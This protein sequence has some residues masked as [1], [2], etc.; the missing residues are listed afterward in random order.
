VGPGDKPDTI[1]RMKQ[2][3]WELIVDESGQPDARLIF[4]KID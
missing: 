4:R 2:K 3:G 1:E